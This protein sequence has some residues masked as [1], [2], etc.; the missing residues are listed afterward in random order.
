MTL[1]ADLE[2]DRL[3]RRRRR[4]TAVIVALRQQADGQ[5]FAPHAGNRHIHKAIMEFEAEVAAINAR[6]SDLSAGAT[7][8]RSP[9]DRLREW[10]AT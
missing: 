10:T 9:R 8:A 7:P 2:R 3:T 5:R 4:V 1:G 6:L